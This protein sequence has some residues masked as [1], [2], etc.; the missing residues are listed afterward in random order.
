MN[1]FPQALNIPLELFQIFSKIRGDICSS[2]SLKLVANEKIFNQ[3]SF[4]YFFGAPL[5]S[6]INIELNFFL[7]V[8]FKRSE[9]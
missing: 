2:R 7:Q 4:N 5:C 9:V 8:H 6:R 1:K 3:K